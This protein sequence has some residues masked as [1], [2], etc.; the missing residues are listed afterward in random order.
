MLV[1]NAD[2]SDPDV[3]RVGADYYLIASSFNRVPGLPVLRSPD[4]VNWTIIGHALQS[5]GVEYD[6]PRHGCGV[7]APALRHHAGLFWIVYPDPDHGIFVVTAEDPAGPWS[8]PHLLKGGRGLIDPCPLWDE[9][10]RAYLVH[11]WAKS[12]AGI[13]NRLTLH[14]MTP[15]ARRLLDEG[16][17]VVDGDAIPGCQILEGPK[18]YRHGGWYWIFAP[19]GGVPTGYQMVFR[20]R[21]IGGPYEHRI[22]L[23]QGDT[24]VNGPH[25]GAWVD[26][27][28]LHF[29]DRGVYG[30]VVHRQPLRW[31]GDGWP[32]IG[33]DGEPESPV[34]WGLT[35]PD[36]SDDFAG[37]EL[38]RQWSWQANPDPAWWSLR[39]EPGHLRLA[40][41]QTGTTDLR[42]LPNVLGQRLPG[43]PCTV[44]TSVSLASTAVGARAGLVVLGKDYA[45]AGVEMTPDGPVLVCAGERRPLPS[46]TAELT[47]HAG[48]DGECRFMFGEP[49][50]ATAGHWIGATLG[51][52]ASASPGPP[53]GHADF[54]PFHVSPPHS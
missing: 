30:R 23:R 18:L 48:P 29:Q 13:N 36:G 5:L 12:R 53:A 10:G 8:R 51:L 22:V 43:A 24:E 41:R 9:D 14:Q 46:A 47:L 32:E 54:G 34:S 7:W 50:S 38:G 15:D 27:F 39:A 28:F 19:A 40:C 44:T 3:I 35:G 52:F 17:V 1:L 4:L 42:Q 31:N 45:W 21:D 2:W 11:G 49:F 33:I 6:E 25:Q 37:P 16:T 26:D 20:A